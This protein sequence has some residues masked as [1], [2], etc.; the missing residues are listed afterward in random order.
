MT[1]EE[2]LKILDDMDDG[3]E[4]CERIAQAI[5]GLTLGDVHYLH[6]LVA[7][8]IAARPTSK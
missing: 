8:D 6:A 3:Q 5:P 4:T 1:R 2:L 7:R